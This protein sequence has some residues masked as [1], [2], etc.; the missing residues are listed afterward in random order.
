[1]YPK[2]I[3]KQLAIINKKL[4]V[5]VADGY[6]NTDQILV[7]SDRSQVLS[8]QLIAHANELIDTLVKMKENIDERI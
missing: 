2:H 6:E 1:M 3:N 7:L 8:D 5:L 4:T